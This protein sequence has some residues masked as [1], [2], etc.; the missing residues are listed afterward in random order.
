M[1]CELAP[2]HVPLGTAERLIQPHCRNQERD[3]ERHGAARA[4]RQL[5][6][7]LKR[8]FRRVED[9]ARSLLRSHMQPD[10]SA[11]APQLG[12]PEVQ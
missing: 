11:R 6:K 3:S 10:P 2:R 4:R 8:A 9:L 5:A 7:K 12:Q 1:E